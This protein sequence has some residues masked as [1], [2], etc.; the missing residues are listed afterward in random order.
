MIGKNPK[1]GFSLVLRD[2][3]RRGFKLFW[4]EK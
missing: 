1:R 2:W 3:Y 4:E